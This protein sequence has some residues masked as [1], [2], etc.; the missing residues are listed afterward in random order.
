MSQYYESLG[1]KEKVRYMNKLDAVV[2]TVEDD[3]Y[4]KESG[5]NV[6]TNMTSWPPLQYRHIFAYFIACPSL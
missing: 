1:S 5:R 2:L 4:S 6:E 3:P